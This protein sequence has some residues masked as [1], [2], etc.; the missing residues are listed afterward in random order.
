MA[1]DSKA[2][3]PKSHRPQERDLRVD[4]WDKFPFRRKEDPFE[5]RSEERKNDDDQSQYEYEGWEQ[6][7]FPNKNVSEKPAESSDTPKSKPSDV[8]SKGD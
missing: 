6:E 2:E 4:Q 1:D 5:N 3:D 8:K 7:A